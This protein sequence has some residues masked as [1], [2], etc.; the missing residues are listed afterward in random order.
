LDHDGRT[1]AP[2]PRSGHLHFGLAFHG[3]YRVPQGKAK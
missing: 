1:S 3:R 2:P